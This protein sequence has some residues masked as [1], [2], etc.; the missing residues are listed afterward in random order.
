MSLPFEIG[1]HLP[2]EVLRDTFGKGRF[3]SGRQ[4]MVVSG[5]IMLMGVCDYA[6]WSFGRHLMQMAR[7]DHKRNPRH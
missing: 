7:S 1:S 3:D 5:A 6:D 4:L 2:G